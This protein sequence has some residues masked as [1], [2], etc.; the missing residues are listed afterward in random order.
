MSW[1]VEFL[2]TIEMTISGT[3]R[4]PRPLKRGVRLIKVSFKVE[5][6]NLGTSATV[7]NI[8]CLLNTVS[9]KYRFHCN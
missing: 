3:F 4:C 8:G 6:I 2:A 1:V 9:V 5:V 7:R